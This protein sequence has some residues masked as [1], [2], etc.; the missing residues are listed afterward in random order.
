MVPLT[1]KQ[2]KSINDLQAMQPKIKD[3]Q[4]KYKNDQEKLNLKTLELYKEQNASPYGGCLPLIIQLPIIIG[5]FTVLKSPEVYVFASEEIYCS[6]STEFLWLKN[7]ADPDTLVLPLL[8]GVT[9]YLT[10]I[11][12]SSNSNVQSQ[13]VINYVMPIMIFLW[14]RSFAAG[15]TLYWVVS[16]TFQIV[17]QLLLA[18]NNLKV[19]T[20]LGL[21]K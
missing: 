6:I 3:I 12:T 11:T 20:D 2:A 21:L 4:E 10:S 8:A 19:Q 9:T 18:R 16:N 14:G 7:L 5:L 1:L 15:L 17:Q 13:K